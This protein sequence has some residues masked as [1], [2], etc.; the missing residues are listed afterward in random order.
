MQ[1]EEQ[2]MELQGTYL[3]ICIV[4]RDLRAVGRTCTAVTMQAWATQSRLHFRSC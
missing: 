2:R 3:L 1:E 4:D